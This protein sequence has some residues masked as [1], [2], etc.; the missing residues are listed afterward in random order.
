MRITVECVADALAT[1]ITPPL[2]V[3]S[4]LAETAQAQKQSSD[5]AARDTRWQTKAWQDKHA[6]SAD[7]LPAYGAD[8]PGPRGSMA[9]PT[10]IS[11][12][13]LDVEYTQCLAA[14]KTRLGNAVRVVVED[15]RKMSIAAATQRVFMVE[16]SEYVTQII[17]DTEV[18]RINT[19]TGVEEICDNRGKWSAP[20][21]A[22]E[23]LGPTAPRSGVTESSGDGSAPGAR[24]SAPRVHVARAVAIFKAKCTTEG[25]YALAPR[26]AMMASGE[27]RTCLAD[28]CLT[29]ECR[30]KH[31]PVCS[32]ELAAT[33]RFFAN[34][35][36]AGDAD[37]FDAEAWA[38]TKGLC[39]EYDRAASRSPR[40]FLKATEPALVRI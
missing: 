9:E 35:R 17:H 19:V 26:G 20:N 37:Q 21:A 30:L 2:Q 11:R 27:R 18:R 8:D 29:L 40:Q 23:C 24:V 38:P 31:V 22:L 36:H 7:N 15:E 28:A 4:L 1:R 34:N 12:A 13:A 10:L 33:R 25:G 5:Q 3:R 16:T 32:H 39:I 6:V 14:A